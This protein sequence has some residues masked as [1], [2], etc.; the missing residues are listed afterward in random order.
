M[1]TWLKSPEIKIRALRYSVHLLLSVWSWSACTIWNP[2]TEMFFGI[3][4]C[5][6]DSEKIIRL[7]SWYS[8]W[9]LDSPVSLSILL[10]L[11]CPWWQKGDTY[12]YLFLA[13]SPR[14]FLQTGLFFVS[15]VIRSLCHPNLSSSKVQVGYPPS[16]LLSWTASAKSAEGN[17]KCM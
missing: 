4:T 16:P 2:P 5:S 11:R 10:P 6:Y 15:L 1:E 7:L 12:L 17:L 14:F 8:L 3:S 13:R 9:L